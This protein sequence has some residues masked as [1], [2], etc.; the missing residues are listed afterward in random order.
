MKKLL[1]AI[2]AGA[3]LTGVLSGCASNNK[4]NK[5]TPE[6]PELVYYTIGDKQSDLP[7]V[8]EKVNA[9]TQEK[10]GATLNMQFIDA[11]A[12]TER[13]QLNMASSD[14]FDMCFTGYVNPFATAVERGGLLAMDEYLESTPA[15]KES[16]PE[17]AWK[18]SK[19]TDGK[20][21]A[22][23]NMQILAFGLHAYTFKD[24]ADKYGLDLDKVHSVE[25]LVPYL[26][27]IK[28]NEP[29]LYPAKYEFLEDAFAADVDRET[30]LSSLLSVTYDENGKGT[31]VPKVTTDYY[32]RDLQKTREWYKKGY[33]RADIASVIDDSQDANMGKYAVWFH[34][35]TPGNLE[36]LTE[37][38][39]KEVV[40]VQID[41]YYIP[42]GSPNATMTAIGRKS[43]YPEKAMKMIELLN[44]DKEVYNLIAFGIEDKHYT[45]LDDLH[46]AYID[47]SGYA[48]KM[49]WAFGNQFNAFL[50]EGMDDDT[51]EQ[52]EKLNN[53]SK[54][55]P[56]MGFMVDTKSISSE[57]SQCQSVIGEYTAALK[58]TMDMD[59]YYDEMVKKLNAA[60]IEK[61]AEEVQ[62]QFDEWYAN[63]K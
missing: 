42:A 10:I 37:K 5:D 11:G 47:N 34:N 55:S 26:E 46:V 23:P 29:S 16:I 15:L 6:V 61:I 53:E 56:Q 51:W 2:M 43:R 18:A 39:G 38:Y 31:I 8:L 50:L 21:Y 25:D 41:D 7:S 60:G 63:Q 17:W 14:T 45:K 9:L 1:S 4:A 30:M 40:A 54:P 22:V 19:G 35:N 24:L 48:P 12:Y 20:I 49:D 27:K 62:R 33:L 59:D 44:T 13:M 32:K 58:G 3:M 36:R 52:T 57:V 28:E